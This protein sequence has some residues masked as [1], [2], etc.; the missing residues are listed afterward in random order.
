MKTLLRSCFVADMARDNRDLFLLN[1][2]ALADARLPFETATDAKIW[3]WVEGFTQ[4]HG[5]VPSISSLRAHF[6][7]PTGDADVCE[8][9]EQLAVVKPLVR[10]DFL[11]YL[12]DKANAR[13][14]KVTLDLAKEISAI[15]TTGIT[16]KGPRGSQT[17]LQGAHDAVR[18]FMERSHE[19]VTP[20]I[21]TRLSGNIMSC[22]QDFTDRYNKVK[23]DP[24]YGLGQFTGIAQIDEALRGARAHELW[25][26]A[27]FTGH[28]KSYFAIHWAYVQAVYYGY[29]TLYFSLEMPLHQIQNIMYTMHSAHEDF[30]KIRKQLGI[31]GLGLVYSKVRDGELSPNEEKFLFDYVVPDL[32]KHPT[33]PHSGPHSIDPRAYGDIQIEVADPDKMDYTIVD[34]RQKAELL[35]A[36][37]PFN[38]IVVDHCGLVSART[39]YTST[40][41]RQNEVLRDLKKLAGSFNRGQGIAVVGLVQINREGYKS[42]S[43]SEGRYNLTN[44]AYANETEK[45]AD[46]VTAT[47][48]DDDIKSMGR[49]LF[50]CL[51]SRDHKPFDRTPV[52]VE[53]DQR[54]LL[55]DRTPYEEIQTKLNKGKETKSVYK[56][57]SP[58]LDVDEL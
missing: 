27:A 47:W 1:Y 39:K 4:A 7:G 46:I 17:K 16:V 8:R 52:R 2:H 14:V 5:H 18:Y 34:M 51:K 36:K 28:M 30:G 38:M 50:Q 31:E 53:F 49:I 20:T 19:V 54:R 33:V 25:I 12:E 6:R 44:L 56:A 42:A 43:K 21:G 32:N 15:A 11:S 55:T 37:N 40:S 29:G 57:K 41:E 9:I 3:E 23:A 35:Y 22:G 10:G 26:H 45:S 58:F 48:A 24:R 13:R